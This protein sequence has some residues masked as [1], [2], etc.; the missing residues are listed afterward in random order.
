MHP[1][2]SITTLVR[3]GFSPVEVNICYLLGEGKTFKEIAGLVFMAPRTVQNKVDALR[4]EFDCLNTTAL[5][6]FMIRNGVI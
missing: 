6:A 2:R 5:I 3:R 1:T 4:A